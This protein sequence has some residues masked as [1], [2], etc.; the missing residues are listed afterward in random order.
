MVLLGQKESEGGLKMTDCKHSYSSIGRTH[1]RRLKCF[2]CGEVKADPRCGLTIGG[3]EVDADPKSCVVHYLGGSVRQS[4]A[5]V[6]E[7]D[8]FVA[9]SECGQSFHWSLIR[10]SHGGGAVEIATRP[11]SV[12]PVA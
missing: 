8:G 9:C 10:R 7:G 12:V 4:Q 2:A 5:V 3:F 11:S 6:D 1:S